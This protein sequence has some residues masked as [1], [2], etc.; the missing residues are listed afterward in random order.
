MRFLFLGDGVMLYP[1]TIGSL[2]SAMEKDEKED[3]Q[4]RVVGDWVPVGFS[5]QR[6]RRHVVV[7]SRAF[8]RIT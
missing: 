2:V 4:E 6:G 8:C 7:P 5:W 1:S 3:G